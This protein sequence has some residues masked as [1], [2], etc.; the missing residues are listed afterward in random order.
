MLDVNEEVAKDFCNSVL[1]VG[2]T[3]RPDFV[4][5]AGARYVIE[6]AKF[7]SA[8]GGNQVGLLMME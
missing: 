2:L 8:I 7:L 6:E 3:K 1:K 4:A 5:K